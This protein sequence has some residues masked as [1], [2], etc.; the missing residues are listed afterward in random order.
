MEYAIKGVKREDRIARGCAIDTMDAAEFRLWLAWLGWDVKIAMRYFGTSRQSLYNWCSSVFPVPKRVA[1]MMDVAV[2]RAIDRRDMIEDM[3]NREFI[4]KE[5]AAAK[6][7][8]EARGTRA[9]EWM[10]KLYGS[11]GS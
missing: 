11:I 2:D 9:E 1:F 4:R 8:R 3:K 6:A 7:E 10:K 5:E